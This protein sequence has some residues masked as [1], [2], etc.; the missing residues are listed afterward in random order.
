MSGACQGQI[1]TQSSQ[2]TEEAMFFKRQ[3]I[4]KILWTDNPWNSLPLDTTGL[5]KHQEKD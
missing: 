5:K 4:Y 1:P 2:E 3:H